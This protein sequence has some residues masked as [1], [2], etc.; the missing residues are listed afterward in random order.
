MSKPSARTRALTN[1]SSGYE[2]N[3]R[4][5]DDEREGNVDPF[6]V[7]SW[8]R[9]SHLRLVVEER[10][11][12]GVDEW[13]RGGAQRERDITGN[14]LHG[15]E[16]QRTRHLAELSQKEET[17]Q[18]TATAEMENTRQ[19]EIRDE[20]TWASLSRGREEMRYRE[21]DERLALKTET[22]ETR[23]RL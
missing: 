9:R 18:K 14:R 8:Q 4:A 20:K 15:G 21:E 3:T 17:D 19:F 5:L 7:G 10:R 13:R 11:F 22:K 16:R 6:G 2:E 23:E 12:G 1:L